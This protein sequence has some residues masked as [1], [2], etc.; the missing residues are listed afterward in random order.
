MDG[1]IEGAGLRGG[2]T[3]VK[4][5]NRGEREVNETDRKIEGEY[6]RRGRK[7]EGQSE[8]NKD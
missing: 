8:M 7:L 4:W 1:V 2:E 5:L 6:E 3:G